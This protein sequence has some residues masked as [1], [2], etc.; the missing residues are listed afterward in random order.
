MRGMIMCIAIGAMALGLAGCE[1]T[2]FGKKNVLINL[3]ELGEN[4]DGKSI[5]EIEKV[6]SKKGFTLNYEWSITRNAYYCN[7]RLWLYSIHSL[8]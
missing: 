2:T 8:R 7:N 3:A 4:I 5:E 6:F 1:P